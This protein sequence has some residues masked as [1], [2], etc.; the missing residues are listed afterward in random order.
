MVATAAGYF[1]FFDGKKSQW[2]QY[3]SFAQFQY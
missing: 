3:D 2:T 1:S